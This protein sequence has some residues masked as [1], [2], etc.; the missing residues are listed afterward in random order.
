MTPATL[1]EQA[2]MRCMDAWV[3]WI[4]T[5]RPDGYP[6][7]PEDTDARDTYATARDALNA[8]WEDYA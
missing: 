6:E 2:A 4:S 7:S 5:A 3:W 8:A 1:R